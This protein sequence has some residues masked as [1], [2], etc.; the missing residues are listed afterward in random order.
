MRSVD[1]FFYDPENKLWSLLQLIRIR[2][3]F[4]EY[5]LGIIS[6]DEELKKSARIERFKN[7]VIKEFKNKGVSR[8]ETINIIQKE[9]EDRG[10]EFLELP[11]IIY[12]I[13]D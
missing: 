8:G 4:S 2:I 1:I 11:K 13:W 10:I 9:F 7:Y 3:S 6:S 12:K 5:E